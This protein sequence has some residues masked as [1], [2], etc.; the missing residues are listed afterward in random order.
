VSLEFLTISKVSDLPG[1]LETATMSIPLPL[2]SKPA[3]CL[4]KTLKLK[5]VSLILHSFNDKKKKKTVI[6]RTGETVWTWVEK[7]R[8]YTKRFPAWGRSSVCNNNVSSSCLGAKILPNCD[9]FKLQPGSVLEKLTIKDD[10]D[11]PRESLT[12]QNENEVTEQIYT[13][14]QSFM[15][16]PRSLCWWCHQKE[17]V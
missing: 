6:T 7:E 15:Y 4:L 17:K 5:L 14:S 12:H 8:T 1:V 10:H 9:W 2:V 13:I 3:N 16:Q 11:D